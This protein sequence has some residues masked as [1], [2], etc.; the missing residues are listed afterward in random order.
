[1]DMVEYCIKAL[2]RSTKKVHLIKCKMIM[3]E[4]LNDGALSI[5]IFQVWQDGYNVINM[6]LGGLLTNVFI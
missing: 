5:A 3:K 2:Q 1:M 6:S 4:T